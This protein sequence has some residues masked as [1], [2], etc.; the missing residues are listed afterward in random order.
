M[1]VRGWLRLPSGLALLL[2]LGALSAAG[3]RTDAAEPDPGSTRATGFGD[4]LI[5]SE[6]GRVYL[7]EGGGAFRHLQL[8][9]TPETRQLLGLLQAS[10]TASTGLRLR[11][12]ILAGDGGDGFHWS[13]IRKLPAPHKSGT[14]TR[15]RGEAPAGQ[16]QTA[17]RTPTAAERAAKS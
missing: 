10:G 12:V 11:P 15:T 9:D 2:G 4:T 5:R 3:A 7:S 14:A 16:P 13:R 6:G 1:R 8:A 17:P